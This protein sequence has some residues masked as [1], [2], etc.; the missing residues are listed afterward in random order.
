LKKLIFFGSTLSSCF[1]LNELLKAGHEISAV[2]TQPDRPA[3]RGKKILMS[4]VKKLALEQNLTIFQPVK[5]RKNPEFREKMERIAPDLNVVVAY[6]QIIPGSI[7]F[8]PKFNSINLHLSLLPKFRGSSPVQWAIL[9]GAE[10]TGITIFELSKKMDEGPIYTKLELA[11]QPGENAAELETRLIRSGAQLLL[12]TI[13]QIPD[14]D[15]L[16]QDHKAA[17][18]VSKLNKEDGLINWTE[19]AVQIDRQVRAFTPWPS[20]F[21]FRQNKRLKLI[22]GKVL[23]KQNCFSGKPGEILQS[24]KNGIE[25]CCQ[26]GTVYLIIEVQP[27]NK[28]IMPAYAFSIGAKLCIGDRFTIND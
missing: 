5:V 26:N 10:K 21:T 20:S 7:I 15:P 6:G 12:D 3:G 8:L 9:K 16:P 14:L 1:C 19:S 13:P 28:K 11:I 18:Y 24:D 22:S 25:V 2:V 23:A 17:T 4:P 27:E